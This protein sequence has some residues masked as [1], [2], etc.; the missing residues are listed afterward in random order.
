[1]KAFVLATVFLM[2]FFALPTFIASPSARAEAEQYFTAAQIQRGLDY[3]FERRLLF[4]PQTALHLGLLLVLCA[5]ARPLTDACARLVAGRWLPTVVLVGVICALAVEALSLPFSLA[6]LELMRAWGLKPQAAGDWLLDHCKRFA[7]FGGV[8]ALILAGF[9]LLMRWLPRTWWLVCGL[10]TVGLAMLT[11]FLLPIWIDPLFNTFTPLQD[12]KWKNLEPSVRYLL[13]KA[14]VEVNDILVMNASRQSTHTNAYFTGF[15][16]T[17]R[18]VL[19]DNLL[20]KH[21]QAEVESI[22]AHELGHWLHDHIVKGIA[23][24]GVGSLLA[25]YLLYRFMGWVRGRAPWLLKS[26]YDPAGLPLILLLGSLSEWA[27]MPVQNLVSRHFETQ[28][29]AMSLELAGQPEAFEQ[30]EV[31]LAVD[32]ISNVAANPWGVLLYSSHPTAVQRIEM[33]REWSRNN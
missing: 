13:V 22:L 21:T 1:M 15:G 29:D 14:G 17:R 2:I 19:Y 28:A 6:R 4:W 20:D 24:G 9:Y 23:L 25:F 10:A 31:K 26:A 11:A 3:S 8:Q 30:A 5:W 32:N 33:A 27:T 18:I 7:I 16:S 12:T